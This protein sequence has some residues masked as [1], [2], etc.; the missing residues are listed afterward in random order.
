M[1]VPILRKSLINQND[2]PATFFRAK[3]LASRLQHPVQ[4]RILIGIG[5]T[6]Y[7]NREPLI[8]QRGAQ[9]VDLG[10]KT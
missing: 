10:G 9:T 1:F 5:K 3:H 8:I 7:S 2:G 4:S 6:G